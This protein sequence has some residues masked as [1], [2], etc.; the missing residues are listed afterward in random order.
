MHGRDTPRPCCSPVPGLPP[1]PTLTWRG[2][3]E[4]AGGNAALMFLERGGSVPT[5]SHP[6]S[7]KCPSAPERKALAGTVLRYAGQWALTLAPTHK[8]SRLRLI[9][10]SA[11]GSEVSFWVFTSRRAGHMLSLATQGPARVLH[12]AVTKNLHQGA[13]CHPLGGISLPQ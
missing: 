4:G 8:R 10:R 11:Q 6:I 13:F 2:R 9:G 5:N 3:K 12:T 7:K 1:R